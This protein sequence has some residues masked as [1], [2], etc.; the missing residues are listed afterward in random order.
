MNL[1]FGVVLAMLEYAMGVFTESMDRTVF[2]MT[3]R[4]KYEV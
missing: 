2:M 3:L 4:T 1:S